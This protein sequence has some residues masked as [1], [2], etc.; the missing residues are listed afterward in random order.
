MAPVILSSPSITSSSLNITI[1]P[2]THDPY[3]LTILV[4]FSYL[5]ARMKNLFHITSLLPYGQARS[6][7]QKSL[8]NKLLEASP[9]SPP[10][11]KK[12]LWRLSLFLLLIPAWHT[13][14]RPLQDSPENAHKNLQPHCK[15]RNKSVFLLVCFGFILFLSKQKNLQEELWGKK[16]QIKIKKQPT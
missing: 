5:N 4:I 6:T 13:P 3:F 16:S 8:P 14:C 2:L 7:L 1:T 10:T 11:P 15:L 9:A 12:H